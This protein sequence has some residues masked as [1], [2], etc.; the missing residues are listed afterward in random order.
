MRTAG[1][2]LAISLPIFYS[3]SAVKSESQT[4]GRSLA[5]APVLWA[6]PDPGSLPAGENITGL[7]IQSRD[8]GRVLYSYSKRSDQGTTDRFF[9]LSLNAGKTFSAEERIQDISETWIDPPPTGLTLLERGLGAVRI[10]DSN[11][12]F[13]MRT[14]RDRRWTAESRVNDELSTVRGAPVFRQAPD[15]S[16]ICV[17]TDM[18]HGFPLVFVSRSSDGGSSW[19]PNKPIEYDFREGDQW[20]PQ[21]AIGAGGRLLAFWEDW[22]DRKTLVDI[23]YAISDDGGEHWR[24]GGKVNDDAKHVWQLDFSVA[25]HGS[26]IYVAFSDF[27]DPG[28]Q[29]DNDWNI[30]F[31]RSENNGNTF[32]PNS[33]LNDVVPGIDKQPRLTVDNEGNLFCAWQSGRRSIFG[34]V[35]VAYSPDSGRIWSRSELIS[36]VDDYGEISGLGISNVGP[37]TVAVTWLEQGHAGDR[38]RMKSVAASG[39]EPLP[40]S[41][42]PDRKARNPL[43]ADSGEL[44][45]SEDFSKPRSGWT[46]SAG[47][48]L[49]VEN[50]LM[51]SVVGKP[52]YFASFAPLEE[53]ESY[54]LEGRFML[55]PVAHFV[56]GIFLRAGPESSR[57]LVIGNQFRVGAWISLKNDDFP[58]KGYRLSGKVLDQTRF[59]FQKGKW[60]PFRV[61]VTPRQID[62]YVDGRL[63]L[64]AETDGLPPPDRIGFG[65][66]TAA[67]TY[68][69]DLKVFSLKP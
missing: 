1:L 38:R 10:H 61:V 25:D 59:P 57:Q 14:D 58:L 22:R 63:M 32:S 36:D 21:L 65:G 52:N 20:G 67:P 24:A 68:F 35:A 6:G 19:T 44:L 48:W 29:G 66:Y 69:D 64:S 50:S 26:N 54:V 41:E 17:W 18:R 7:S 11:I 34:D 42:E 27:R 51:G 13:R 40:A 5:E 49:N 31:S 62:Y 56:A 39:T 33:R 23:R 9:R 45:Y 43:N 16:I 30:Y 3:A 4:S 37:G 8:G 2:I 12:Y 47:V 28:E 46:D 15:G 55:D 60:Y 53:P